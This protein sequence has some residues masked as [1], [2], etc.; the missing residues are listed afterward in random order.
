VGIL[1]IHWN[2]CFV[3]ANKLKALKGDLKKWNADEF[4]HVTMKKNMMI[5]DLREFDVVEESRPLSM[6]EKCKKETTM[7]S[8]TSLF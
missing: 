5:A 1:S 7:W 8:W 2:A 4:G 3:F 6:E